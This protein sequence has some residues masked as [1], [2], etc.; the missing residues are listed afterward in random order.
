MTMAQEAERMCESKTRSRDGAREVACILLQRHQTTDR[1]RD[2]RIIH[3]GV[4]T[5]T[6][7]MLGWDEHGHE[8]ALP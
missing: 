8:A 6:G 3:A 2:G 5:A 4:D 7:E 1:L